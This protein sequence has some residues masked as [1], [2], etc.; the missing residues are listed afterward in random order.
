[1]FVDSRKTITRS[2]SDLGGVDRRLDLHGPAA[3]CSVPDI[4]TSP[5]NVST[6]SA[7]TSNRAT[8]LSVSGEG[9][10]ITLAPSRGSSFRGGGGGGGWG[11]GGGGFSLFSGGGWGGGGTRESLSYDQRG[12]IRNADDEFSCRDPIG[13]VVETTPAIALAYLEKYS[14]ILLGTNESSF[15]KGCTRHSLA[16]LPVC[17]RKAGRI[18]RRST[19]DAAISAMLIGGPTRGSLLFAYGVGEG[20]GR[21]CEDVLSVT[22]RIVAPRERK[23]GVGGKRI[24]SLT[25]GRRH[26]L[27]RCQSRSNF[28]IRY[29]RTETCTQITSRPS[30]T[31]TRQQVEQ[32]GL[33]QRTM[34]MSWECR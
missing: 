3:A 6:D 33:D 20:W 2:T 28:G 17:L 7:Q 11:G 19:R 29:L 12:V 26:S 5:V 16:L 13:V 15:K 30:L 9:T 22:Q 18:M 24:P 21:R 1:V 32:C 31:S 14:R 27:I 25:V 4:K 23:G 34:R 10:P 8:S